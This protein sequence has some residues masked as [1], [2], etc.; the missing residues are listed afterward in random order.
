[1]RRFVLTLLLTILLAGCASEPATVATPTPAPPADRAPALVWGSTDE[2][3]TVSPVT[4]QNVSVPIHAQG[5]TEGE[6]CP[7]SGA[8]EECAILLPAEGTP[9]ELPV[10]DRP[11]LLMLTIDVDEPAAANGCAWA[12][13][14]I[15]DG[16]AWRSLGADGFGVFTGAP[17]VVSWSLRELPAGS[18][19]HLAVY[20]G[21]DTHLADGAA[22]LYHGWAVPFRVEGTLFHET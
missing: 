7:G 9:F 5:T 14:R 15:R 2:A 8:M 13:L 22:T 21:S 16:D 3:P 1:M 19:Y 18:S 6:T 12:V 17:L 20:C 10:V 4:V 11:T